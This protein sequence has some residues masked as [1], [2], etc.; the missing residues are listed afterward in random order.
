LGDAPAT[1][2]AWGGD[3]VHGHLEAGSLARQPARLFHILVDVQVMLGLSYWIYLIVCGAG[4]RY[5]AFPFLLHP[6]VGLLGGA[7]AQRP[8]AS[9]AWRR[10]WVAG[11][12][13][14]R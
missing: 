13:W 9:W 7:L 2:A 4:A 8:C 5:L 6:I 3:L 14:R 1:P 10:A 12:H 11:H